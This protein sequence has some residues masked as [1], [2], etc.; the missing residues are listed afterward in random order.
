[1]R[2]KLKNKICIICN[3]N[4]KEK[5]SYCLKCHNERNREI[6]KQKREG[7]FVRKWKKRL[8][9]LESVERKLELA[10]YHRKY[11]N[12]NREELRIKLRERENKIKLEGI[13]K[14]GGKCSCCGEE[15]IEFLTLEHLKGRRKDTDVPYKAKKA[16]L[17]LKTLN[18]P[19][20]GY[21]ILCFNCNCAK[22]IYGKCPHQK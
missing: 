13:K 6:S 1:M 7:T 2:Y 4:S 5:G 9:S 12:E 18:W 3:I 21:T 14:Y 11:K 17:R 22:G 19:K 15:Q 10:E 20:E 8:T 16:W